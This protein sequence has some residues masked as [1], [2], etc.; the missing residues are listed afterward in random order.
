MSKQMDQKVI[1][2]IEAGSAPQLKKVVAEIKSQGLTLND[3]M[4]T[5]NYLEVC[6]AS[7]SSRAI[8]KIILQEKISPLLA[9]HEPNAV[10]YT[11]V[12]GLEVPLLRFF[13]DNGADV[14]IPCL[15]DIDTTLDGAYQADPNQMLDDAEREHS[16]EKPLFCSALEQSGNN[17]NYNPVVRCLLKAP[18]LDL[19]RTD[20]NGDTAVTYAAAFAEIA[21]L[22]KI[23]TKSPQG[24]KSPNKNLL[25][26][27]A[28]HE[29]LDNVKFLLAQGVSANDIAS[30]RDCDALGVILQKHNHILTEY[31][32]ESASGDIPAADK[33]TLKIHSVYLK[34][35]KKIAKV[36][37]KHGA[38]PDNCPATQEAFAQAQQ[39]NKGFLVRELSAQAHNEQPGR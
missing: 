37:I 33:Q 19:A 34:H 13:V 3:C 29:R 24:L 12:E 15:D 9:L 6:Y 36:L 8:Y 17:N 27:A 26:C 5:K 7:Q 30:E 28:E 22:K 1:A 32:D 35:L 25:V 14:N 2:A 31:N 16:R 4:E 10:I 39:I 23:V 38:R 20:E 11:L 21:T 18:N